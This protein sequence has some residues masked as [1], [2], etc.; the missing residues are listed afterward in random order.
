MPS[1][2]IALVNASTTLADTDIAVVI[3]SLQT[4][5]SQHFSPAW[6]MDATV[7]FVPKGSQPPAG[8]WWL[9]AL[10]NSDQAGALGYHDLTN[11]GLPLGK[12]FAATDA[13]YSEKWTVTASHELLEMLGD[14][15]IDLTVFVQSS[16]TAGTIYAYEV[17]DACEADAYA[18][19]INGV[20]VSD[21]V[22]PSFFESFYQGKNV[23]FDYSNKIT[24]PFQILSGGYLSIY[25]VATGG[26]WRQI[27]AAGESNTYAMR[28]RVGSRRE[29]RRIPK[30]QWLRSTPKFS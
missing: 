26:G 20:T 16:D 23:Q 15:E 1:T 19:D 14:P 22:F 6:G 28:P 8:S 5:V 3:P 30:D 11:E 13:L 7:Q 2:L 10:D 21:F 17:C 4:Q 29:R 9:V 12:V 27:T 24:T 25:D 18:Y